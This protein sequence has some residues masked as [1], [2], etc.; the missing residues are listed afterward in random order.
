MLLHACI[1]WPDNANLE[2]WPFALEHAIWIWN[3]VP[4]RDALLAPME[5][6]T[7]SKF[8]SY[9]HLHRAHVFGCPAYVLDPKLQDGKKLPKWTPRSR[10]G[11]Y[12][13]PSPDHSTLVGR[14]LNLRTGSVSPQFHVVY[15][16]LF[17]TVPNAE[18]G[19]ILDVEN[20][21]EE[22]WRTLIQSGI[23]RTLWREYDENGQLIPV[24][25]L[26]DEW[27]TPAE[28]KLRD[29]GH[30][31]RR[32]RRAQLRREEHVP[33]S[34]DIS[35][36]RT[37]GHNDSHNDQPKDHSESEPVSAP[38]GEGHRES[39][40]GSN[41]DSRPP[42]DAI[43]FDDTQIDFDED[44]D[45]DLSDPTPVKDDDRSIRSLEPFIEPEDIP[46]ID[47]MEDIPPLEE[48]D[49]DDESSSGSEASRPTERTK[50]KRRPNRRIFNEDF[51]VYAAKAKTRLST[52]N[53]QYLQMLNW[54]MA[55]R[56]IRSHD[57][58]AM[59]T[60]AQQHTDPYDNTVEWM[61]P[62]ILG[63]KANSEDT[64][65]WEQAMNGPDADGYWKACEKEISTL[66]EDKD[67]WD[68]VARETWMN[69][70]P[71]TWAFKC[72]RFPDGRVRKLKARFCV[73]GDRQVE[74]VDFFDAFA[75]VVN[76][77]T[78][79][80]MLM[81]SAVLGLSTRQVDYTA[82]FVHAPM[83]EDVHVNMPRG[84]SEPGKVLKLKKSLYGLKQ[85][86]RNFF[87][88]L[89]SKLENV[90]F[91]SAMDIDPC[92]FISD[93]VICLVYVD[94]TLFY[95][96]KPE[97]IDEVIQ[98]LRDEG[99]D[100]EEEE[101]VAGFLG[102]HIERNNS[103]GTITLTQ[104]GLIKR[105]IDTLNLHSQ[106]RKQTPATANPLVMDADG[107]PPN[108]TYNYASVVGMLQYL[109]GHSRPDITFAVS[110]CARHVHRTRR[111]HE[112]A[113]ERIG[114]YLKGTMDKGLILKP[115]GILDIDCYVDADFAGLWP[116]EDKN[117]PT[118]VK[119]RTG[120]VICIS[121]CPVIWSSKLQTDIATST[122]EAEYNGLSLCMRDLI[123]FKRLFLSVARGIGLTDDT[124]TTFKTT[125]WEDNNGAL[126]LANMEPGRMTPR[127][128]HCAVKC[129]WFRSH[130][131]PNQV[132]VHKIDTELQKADI[133]TK[134]LRSEKFVA[135][136]KLLCGW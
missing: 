8:P 62:M 21:R 103:D 26:D 50:R 132:E 58:R 99:M 120:F 7:S 133:L 119:S 67:A 68:V 29:L 37:S 101:D 135:I 16:D 114:L 113:I 6:F 45:D 52:L 55:I 78:V 56:S 123:P 34:S 104:S 36:T 108:G 59:A 125:A 3:N 51:H 72:K 98:K 76:W 33:R 109:Q 83:N 43:E 18:H 30:R 17:T 96:P 84:F 94:D 31:A 85:S 20:F 115:T 1:H 53:D 25:S 32:T 106:Y 110:Q 13:G 130:L 122:M 44:L 82:A 27:L 12:L 57:M 71:S 35:P 116:H 95:S 54:K 22:R 89:K 126:T 81:L 107:D 60:L 46:D 121:N 118:C 128:K 10:R 127:S 87:Q 24:P 47:D 69:V 2:L 77:T 61:H 49:I 88:F 48:H 86:P 91:E 124:M 5:L 66:V 28:I 102:V 80:L 38:E 75:P 70:L 93:K 65:S 131:K 105:I 92:L 117:D 111:S 9:A 39:I 136:R 73:R 42:V 41:T 63:S 11:Q 134:G 19:G 64:P 4:N 112:I 40:T 23:E 74:G 15:D 90:G 100:L 129:H 14:I 79:R 97:Y